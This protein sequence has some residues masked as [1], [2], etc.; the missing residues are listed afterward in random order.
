MVKRSIGWQMGFLRTLRVS[1]FPEPLPDLFAVFIVEHPLESDHAFDGDIFMGEPLTEIV[2]IVVS[3]DF[4]NHIPVSDNT[5][6][7]H[8]SIS[9]KRW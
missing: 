2:Q 6:L 5:K 4:N 3:Q 8:V 9:C 7:W 1:V